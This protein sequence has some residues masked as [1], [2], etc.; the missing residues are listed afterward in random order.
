M[1]GGERPGLLWSASKTLQGSQ[2]KAALSGREPGGMALGAAQHSVCCLR[3]GQALTVATGRPALALH[4]IVPS[5]NA[6]LCIA[7]PATDMSFLAVAQL[8]EDSKGKLVGVA[9]L[10]KR[11]LA[12]PEYATGDGQEAVRRL[13]WRMVYADHC[14]YLSYTV[15]QR[16]AVSQIAINGFIVCSRKHSVFQQVAHASLLAATGVPAGSRTVNE[17]CKI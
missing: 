8:E 3:T 15:M 1:H 6:A 11:T 4:C 10:G 2:S 13:T 17:S 7:V 9:R 16:F 5:G 14:Y 12:M